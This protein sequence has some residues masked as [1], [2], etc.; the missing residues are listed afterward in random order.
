MDLVADA[1]TRPGKVNTV[2]FGNGLDK[3]VIVSVFEPALQGVVIDVCHTTL[4]FYPGYTHGLKLQVGHGAG[5]VLGEGLVNA[6]T[7][8]FTHV[9]L[10]AN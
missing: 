8:V 5:G 1:V 7:N 4:S 2:L 9:H 10:A 6:Q 3:P